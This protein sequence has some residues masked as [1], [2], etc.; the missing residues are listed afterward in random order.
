M[1]TSDISK[2]EIVSTLRDNEI[3]FYYLKGV[4]CVFFTGAT[5]KDVLLS[6][7]YNDVWTIEDRADLNI[8]LEGKEDV[9][10]SLLD[11]YSEYTG[12]AG[13]YSTEVKHPE[14]PDKLVECYVRTDVLDKDQVK[15]YLHDGWAGCPYCED[16]HNIEVG[17]VKIKG[18][19][20]R[21]EL[22]CTSCGGEWTD[23]YTLSG[24]IQHL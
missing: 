10:V 6:D 7:I 8:V 23:V 18:P 17:F 20:A 9:I 5:A 11:S 13:L 2:K 4:P 16:S 22:F 12:P 15:Q 14:N 24:I 21:Q 1:S 3:P 19:R